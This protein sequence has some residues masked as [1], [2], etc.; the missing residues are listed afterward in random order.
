MKLLIVSQHFYPENFRIND[1]AFSLAKRGHDV[2]VLT[3]LPNY[4]KGKVFPEYRHGQNRHQNVE[5]VKIERCSLVGR[6][7]SLLTFG[8]NYAWFAISA[9]L[10][11]RSLKEKFDAVY[12]YQT[13]PV[14]MSRPAIAAAKKQH[15][16]LILNCLDQ[17]PISV[18][19]GPINEK[20]LFYKILYRYSVNTYNK[21][22]LITIT[23][24]SF[25]NY[26]EKTLKLPAEKYGLVYWPQYAE[27][28]YGASTHEK[29]GVYDV[30]YAGNVGPA[31]DV[32]VIVKAAVRL[33]DHDK[34]HFHIVGDGLNL[35]ACKE[36]AE[37]AGLRN[38]TFHGSHPVSEMVKYY[39]LADAFLITMKDN[40]VVNYTLPAKMQ[41]YMLAGKPVIGAVNGETQRVI[42]EC[43]CGY[44]ADAGDDEKLAEYILTASEDEYDEKKM[45]EKAKAYY[46]A[47]FDKE[48]LL[49]QLEEMFA[50]LI[51]K[52][53]G[54]KA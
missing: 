41:S 22:D 37:K 25:K 43:G 34:I 18:T 49:D 14:S 33:K 1:I 40:Q 21:A 3:G 19:A 36:I 28:T 12:S 16:P 26:F 8:I 2:T 24:K 7:T 20:S 51:R 11:A 48:K 6:G 13:S 53:K 31:T 9:T 23:S 44:C 45:G 35:P 39:S 15:I 5:G 38:I 47:H 30:L 27:D 17:W 29:N 52:K 10:K 32:E 46:Q 54:E 50:E 4:P 42:R